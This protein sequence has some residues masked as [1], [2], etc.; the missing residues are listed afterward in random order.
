M[1]TG[2]CHHCQKGGNKKAGLKSWLEVKRKLTAHQNSNMV[3]WWFKQAPAT[4]ENVL[5]VHMCACA[6]GCVRICVCMCVCVYQFFSSF[7][8][9]INCRE[10]SIKHFNRQAITSCG[11]YKNKPVNSLLLDALCETGLTEVLRAQPGTTDSQVTSKKKKNYFKADTVFPV[12]SELH[13]RVGSPGVRSLCPE[14]L[15]WGLFPVLKE[16]HS[17]VDLNWCM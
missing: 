6:Y 17:T 4:S 1:I 3:F 13:F 8:P 16:R 2:L 10:Q 7:P 14:S 9:C 12:V 15:C 5:C 11:Y